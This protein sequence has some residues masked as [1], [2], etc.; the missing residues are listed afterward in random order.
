MDEKQKHEMMFV[1]LVY[2]FHA[3]AMHQLGKLKNPLTDKIER[4]LGAAQGTIDMIDM[5]KTKT[6]GNLS[7][8]E[9]RMLS[10]LLMELRLNYVD[11]A[12]KPEPAK[13]EGTT[14]P[15]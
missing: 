5:L 4:D 2:M 6:K 13:Q 7:A 12:S 10:S 8:E 11:E 15:S 3:A 1:Q 14:Q 9:D